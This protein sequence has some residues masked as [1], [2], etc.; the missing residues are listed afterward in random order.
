MYTG[1]NWEYALPT[2]VPWNGF[3][4]AQRIIQSTDTQKWYSYI[5][6]IVRTS[7]VPVIC[8]HGLGKE[9]MYYYLQRHVSMRDFW[10]TFYNKWKTGGNTVRKDMFTAYFSFISFICLHVDDYIWTVNLKNTGYYFNYPKNCLI[11][12]LT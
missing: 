8:I 3:F 10:V 7:G 9:N 5:S 4:C 1:M 12:N 11:W 6:H 2:L